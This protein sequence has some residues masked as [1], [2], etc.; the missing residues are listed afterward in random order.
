MQIERPRSRRARPLA[1]LAARAPPVAAWS[2]AALG[3]VGRATERL[4]LLGAGEQSRKRRR[5]GGAGARKRVRVS[6]LGE[7]VVRVHAGL[8]RLRDVVVRGGA[9]E[10]G[11]ST[12]TESHTRCES[13]AGFAISSD[14]SLSVR[15]GE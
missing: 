1:P 6:G 2:H 12:D 10:D 8:L 11:D 15:G 9:G 5:S 7:V 4:L 3:H 13:V 14:G